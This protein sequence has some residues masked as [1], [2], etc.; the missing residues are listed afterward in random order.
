MG[1]RRGLGSHEGSDLGEVV[2]EE[3][4]AL[5]GRRLV[6]CGVRGSRGQVQAA[7]GSRAS[8]RV[9]CASA[10]AAGDGSLLVVF[11]FANDTALTGSLRKHRPE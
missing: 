6:V 5:R 3:G 8:S 2:G 10:A 1:G 4:G 9:C 11:L 7:L